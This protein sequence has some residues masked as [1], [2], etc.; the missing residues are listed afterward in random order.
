MITTRDKETVEGFVES[1]TES[2]RFFAKGKIPEKDIR[3]MA[4]YEVNRLDFN[5]DWQMHKGL[6]Y[7]AMSAVNRYLLKSEMK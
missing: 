4:E 6:G 2:I 1:M 7:F 3:N 5:N